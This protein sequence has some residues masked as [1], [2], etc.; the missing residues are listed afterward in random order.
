MVL[1]KLMR[2]SCAWEYV[3]NTICF[4]PGICLHWQ[5]LSMRT[6]SSSQDGRGAPCILIDYLL[7]EPWFGATLL[8][9][10][11]NPEKSTFNLFEQKKCFKKTLID[12]HSFFFLEAK[13]LQDL[14]CSFVSFYLFVLKITGKR[15]EN[16]FYECFIWKTQDSVIQ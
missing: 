11:R 2:I 12:S 8:L 16:L 3:K 4:L 14:I 15:G 6:F 5:Q 13:F 1:R 9:A 7:K 10:N